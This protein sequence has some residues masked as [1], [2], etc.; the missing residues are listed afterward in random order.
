MGSVSESEES[1]G[2]DE[3]FDVYD[4]SDDADNKKV[5]TDEEATVSDG[6]R[7]TEE[8]VNRVLT[9]DIAPGPTEEEVA[10]DLVFEDDRDELERLHSMF[11]PSEDA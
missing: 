1:K 11:K 6:D 4:E 5:N 8:E 10:M 3:E 7:P 9:E 2:D